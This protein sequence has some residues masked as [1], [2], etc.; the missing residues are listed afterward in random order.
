MEQRI[1]FVV[2]RIGVKGSPERKSADAWLRNIVEPVCRELQL[3]TVRSDQI[4]APGRIDAQVGKYLLDSA[5]VIADLTGLNPNVMYEV[6]VRHALDLPIV[7]MA[8]RET[9]LPFDFRTVRI[10][11]YDASLHP[12]LVTEARQGLSEAAVAA[13][14]DAGAPFLS[15][16]EHGSAGVD[17]AGEWDVKFSHEDP[18]RRDITFELRQRGEK[19]WG[20]SIHRKKSE[21]IPG[22]SVRTYAQKGQIY[23]RFV[24]LNGKS[25]TPQ[26]LL[27][28]TFLLEVVGDGRELR[29]GVL[30]YSTVE[31][32][33][34]IK[35]CSCVRVNV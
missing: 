28:N 13:L 7:H 8:A 2:S 35:K 6:G 25:P 4:S 12:D 11:D 27:I 21:H 1:A 10:I 3:A 33:I 34:I 31:G 9:D 16:S 18:H 32:G 29:G 23:N 15:N 14:N 30:A 24:Q 17:L 26:R 19:L 22:D 5:V 20:V